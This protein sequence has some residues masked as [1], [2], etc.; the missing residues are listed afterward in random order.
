[1]RLAACLLI[2]IACGAAEDPI[3]RLRFADGVRRSLDDFDQR[4]LIVGW[5]CGDCP[6]SAHFLRTDG[7][8]LHDAI[9]TRK[10]PLSLVFVTPDKSPAQLAGYP[11]DMGLTHALF[12]HDPDNVENISLRNTCSIHAMGTDGSRV[13]FFP[14]DQPFVESAISFA[15]G[16]SLRFPVEGLVDPRAIELW[17]Q[18]ENRRPQAMAT[19]TAAARKSAIKDEAARILA[20]IQPAFTARQDELVAAPA[21]I[22]TYEAIERLLR[23]GEG[24]ELKAAQARGKELAKAPE[25]KDELA[26]RRIWQQCAAMAQSNKPAEQAAAKDNLAKLAKKYPDT[27]YG[28]M[29]AGG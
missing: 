21:T 4:V 15:E 26:A 10:L 5:F 19:L 7:K 2:V 27:K 12:A 28:R 16:G 6:G 8:S 20:V 13:R 9:E 17:W 25:L 18:V 11:A 29:A 3:A 1:M 23:D 22:E 14:S 24:L